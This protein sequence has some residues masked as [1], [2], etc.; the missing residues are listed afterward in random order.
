MRFAKALCFFL[1]RTSV[2]FRKGAAI[3]R[4]LR[5]KAT[6]LGSKTFHGRSNR[7]IQPVSLK[8]SHLSG[9]TEMA[10]QTL[11]AILATLPWSPWSRAAETVGNVEESAT[12]LFPYTPGIPQVTYPMVQPIPLFS[13]RSSSQMGSCSYLTYAPR[14]CFQNQAQG[15]QV[16]SLGVHPPE[17]Q[18]MP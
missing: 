7:F 16:P 12:Y 14:N 18:T 9:R 13:N 5:P 11:S 17:I 6:R 8:V 4:L 10:M 1:C 3:A 2:C 15:L